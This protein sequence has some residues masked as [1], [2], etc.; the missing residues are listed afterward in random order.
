M[1]LRLGF[2]GARI[3]VALD[4]DY[5]QDDNRCG[6]IHSVTAEAH[7]APLVRKFDN[8]AHQPLSTAAGKEALCPDARKSASPR[9]SGMQG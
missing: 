3:G 4:P 9:L 6:I 1:R 5:R 7:N 8:G 2:L